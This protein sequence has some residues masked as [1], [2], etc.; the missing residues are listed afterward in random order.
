M[1]K[2]HFYLYQNIIKKIKNQIIK[3]SINKII[4]L[5][6]VVINTSKSN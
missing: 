1:W 5:S 3:N 4:A 2:K 6:L